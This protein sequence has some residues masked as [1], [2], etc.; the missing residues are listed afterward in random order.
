MANY[1]GD[2]TN[3]EKEIAV[4]LV[5]SLKFSLLSIHELR[6]TKPCKNLDQ[7]IIWWTDYRIQ[8]LRNVKYMQRPMIHVEIIQ[9]ELL[10]MARYLL[11]ERELY[12]TTKESKLKKLELYFKA[13][14]D[15]RS[16][17][18]GKW[19]ICTTDLEIAFTAG[20]GR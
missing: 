14:Y 17:E 10:A 11:I 7:A 6:Q 1:L 4:L 18:S 3:K 8:I 15:V 12:F 16:E 9:E 13:D 2:Y 5:N 20:G 19:E